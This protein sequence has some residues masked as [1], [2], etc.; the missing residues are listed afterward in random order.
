MR[1]FK[2]YIKASFT[3]KLPRIWV[4]WMFEKW[5]KMQCSAAPHLLA[6]SFKFKITN[7]CTS[8]FPVEQR[9]WWQKLLR[10]LIVSFHAASRIAGM[11][12][13][14][15]A[16]SLLSIWHTDGVGSPLITSCSPPWI[17]LVGSVSCSAFCCSQQLGTLNFLGVLWLWIWHLLSE[18][19]LLLGSLMPP[20]DFSVF[21]HS[22]LN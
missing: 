19:W 16:G 5:T 8:L 20:H 22:Q 11:S 14:K 21:V 2:R 17:F 1:C 7:C 9:N 6:F 3:C 18:P 12:Q 4:S 13:V 15:L 10:Q